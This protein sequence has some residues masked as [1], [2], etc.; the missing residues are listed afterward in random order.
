MFV[1]LVEAIGNP[2]T[3][4]CT[5]ANSGNGSGSTTAIDTRSLEISCL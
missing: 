4:E 3:I 1:C 5:D 2:E